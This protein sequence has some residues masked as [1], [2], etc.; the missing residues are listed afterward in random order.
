MN[1]L[2][3]SYPASLHLVMI[4]GNGQM[5]NVYHDH[6]SKN[7]HHYFLL[8]PF[9][10]TSLLNFGLHD[11]NYL[12]HKCLKPQNLH[13]QPDFDNSHSQFDYLSH[14]NIDWVLL[15]LLH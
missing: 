14:L 10:L 11:S 1:T 2:A 12:D 9:L 4:E 7:Y 15:L 3:I 5:R 13:Y 6:L 8:D